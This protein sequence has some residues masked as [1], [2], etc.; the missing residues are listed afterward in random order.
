MTKITLHEDD[1]MEEC[2]LRNIFMVTGALGFTHVRLSVH[3]SGI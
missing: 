3:M 2:V 1:K